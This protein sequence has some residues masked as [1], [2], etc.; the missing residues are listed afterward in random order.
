[1]AYIRAFTTILRPLRAISRWQ[2][3]K[4]VVNALMYAIPSIINVLLV[5][6]V[7]WLIFSI[8]GV[9][10][11]GG[12][13]YKCVDEHNERLSVDIVGDR[14]E[15]ADKNYSWV[16]SKITFDH[17]GHAYL[18]LFQ[19]ATF[20]GWME[21]MAD[22]VDATEVDQ[23]PQYEA[24]LYNYFYFVIFIVCGSFFTLNLFIG[25]IIDNF[26][27]LKKKYEG[28]VLEMF[29]TES[30][31]N[32]Y[33]AMKKLGTKKPQKVI[34]RPKNE[35]HALFY[36][37][38]L[39]RRFEIAIFV[40]IFLNMVSMGI[41]HYNQA[42]VVTFTL[43]ICNA[44]FTTIFSLECLVKIIGLRYQYFT[45]GW[46]I[47]D[48]ILVIASIVGIVMEDL[49]EDFPV[50]PTLLRVAR[51]CRIG[52]ILRLIKAAKGIRKLLFALIV[53]LPALFNIGALLA[54]ITF[55]YAIIGMTLF[56]HVKH[57]GALNDQVNF[58]TFD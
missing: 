21:I 57:R 5:C 15:C 51:V 37:I 53:S 17:V 38:S 3:M 29:L 35:V 14:W 19:V 30:Q 41:E 22:A 54:L 40:L 50:S 56:G 39:S 20:E 24:S 16:N 32:Y 47:F 44:L 8:M 11:F 2:G 48:F 45:A 27:A 49:M 13:F 6:L 4:I 42:R 10:F 36:D 55:I 18:A 7:F 31:K 28:G 52:R 1:M 25:V 34:Q 12:K 23:Q 26:N 43:E 58:E 46:N 33:T 9:Q